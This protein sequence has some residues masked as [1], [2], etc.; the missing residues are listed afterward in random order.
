[1][2]NFTEE[3]GGG[4]IQLANGSVCDI[5]SEGMVKLRMHDGALCNLGALK[6]F[7]D[8]WAIYHYDCWTLK[9]VRLPFKVDS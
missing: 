5:T 1:M 8:V 4:T 7:P 9:D 2:F 6:F 3:K